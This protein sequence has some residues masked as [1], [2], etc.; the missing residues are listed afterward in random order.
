MNKTLC[1]MYELLNDDNVSERMKED[2]FETMVF[3]AN[4]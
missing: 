3:L 2:I 4:K 1:N